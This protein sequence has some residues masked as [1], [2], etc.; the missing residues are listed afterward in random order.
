MQE[1][2]PNSANPNENEDTKKLSG[3]FIR[4]SKS[5]YA[6]YKTIRKSEEP[7]ANFNADQQT[8]PDLTLEGVE[9]ANKEAESFFSNLNPDETSLFFVSSNEARAIETADIYREVAHRKAFD[10][11]KP[12]HARSTLSEENSDGEI[13]IL[14]NL[15]IYPNESKIVF[16]GMF[17]PKKYRGE[18]NWDKI[19]DDIREKYERAI[20]IIDADDQ[21]SFVSNF[22]KHAEKIKEIIPEIDTPEELYNS[23]FKNLIRLAKFGEKKMKENSQGKSIKILAF[24]HENY[25]V[26]FLQKYLEKE[27]IGNCEFINFEV[28]DGDV[29]F[30]SKGNKINF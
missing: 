15:S 12:E 21:G 17:N 2:I 26:Y 10:V 16:D 14:S 8:V 1:R 23:Q 7:L 30:E 3:S 18:I 11:I 19:P 5:S 20:E 13:R 27:N 22:A 25:L 9:L 4:H 6:T 29:V 24:G 28:S